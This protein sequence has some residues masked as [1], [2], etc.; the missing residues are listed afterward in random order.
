V[1]TTRRHRRPEFQRPRLAAEA[2]RLGY[3]LLGEDEIL[4]RLALMIL[5]HVRCDARF[6][7][8]VADRSGKLHLAEGG[9][10]QHRHGESG[11]TWGHR[12]PHQ[13]VGVFEVADDDRGIGTCPDSLAGSGRQPNN[14]IMIRFSSR[15]VTLRSSGSEST[16]Q[17]TRCA[18]VLTRY[19]TVTPLHLNGRA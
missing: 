4:A 19:A 17:P 8:L 18:L 2:I 10:Q 16:L 3:L 9:E 12:L 1:P 6:D 5:Q 7:G 11:G 13:N 15:N 14:R